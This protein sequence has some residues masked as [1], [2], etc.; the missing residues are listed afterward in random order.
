MLRSLYSGISGL[1]AQ[2]TMLDVTANNIA[3]VNTTGFKSSSVQFQDALSQQLRGA[4][5][6]TANRGGTDGAQVGLG[7]R[8]A[9][10][11]KNLTEGAAQTTGSQY[12]MMINGDGYFVVNNGGTNQ[13][14]RAGSFHLD[15]AG[16]LATANGNIVQGWTAQNG[17]VN[18]G[19]A[20][21]DLRIPLAQMSQPQRTTGATASG[22]LPSDAA[23]GTTLE[24]DITVY[25]ASGATSQLSLTFTK[26]NTG[27]NA[28]TTDSNGATAAV[29]LTFTDGKLTAPTSLTSSS[30]VV[31]ELGAVT[32]YAGS[33]TVGLKTQN[34]SA[35][36]SLQSFTVNADGTLVGT[37]SNGR[38]EA[39]A[40][41]A[42]AT[43]AN[44][45]GLE[46]AGNSNFIVST[47][48][49]VAQYGTAGDAGFGSIS[50]GALEMSN[51]DL[52]QE[53]TNLIIAQRAF[54]A[55]ARVITASD[56]ILQELTNLKQ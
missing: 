30:G 19:G 34:G 48:S 12:D 14:T 33:T 16:N 15:A 9:G 22:N 11:A 36:G 53:F 49:G 26:T 38:Q 40:Q 6:P 5:G 56:Q 47:N 8:T 23:A 29:P 24:R 52:S 50:S 51:V 13:Y 44:P 54:Q 3:N 31:A 32:S 46:A 37:F 41:V 45:N 39:I 27:W 2:Q 35:A 25:D 4:T 28:A 21:Q 18:T 7:V 42:V 55:N 20:P 1:Q 17:Q 10:V 43:F